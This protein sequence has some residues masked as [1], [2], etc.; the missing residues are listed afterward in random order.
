MERNVGKYR[1]HQKYIFHVIKSTCPIYFFT[2]CSLHSRTWPAPPSPTL[3]PASIPYFIVQPSQIHQDRRLWPL[4]RSPSHQPSSEPHWHWRNA[5]V[6]DAPP[7]ELA[8]CL[9]VR[10]PT[11]TLFLVLALS[12]YSGFALNL[13]TGFGK[14][15]CKGA[16]QFHG[17]ERHPLLI[18]LCFPILSM[19][20]KE[21]NRNKYR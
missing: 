5:M 20:W 3:I 14:M 17:M 2:P 11:T 12:M 1:S 16:K 4:H 18:A 7:R 10:L 6:A 9:P 13:R 21:I 8:R 19:T 15:I